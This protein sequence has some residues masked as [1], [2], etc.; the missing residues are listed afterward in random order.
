MF[1]SNKEILMLDGIYHEVGHLEQ[2]A[3]ED[4]HYYGYL[5][6]AAL[7]SSSIKMLLQSPKT[8][9]YVTKYGGNNNSKALLIGKL[10]HLSV[11]EPHKM[12]EVLV[13]DVQSRATKKFKEVAA[14]N[15]GV[16]VITAAEEKEVRRLQDHMLRN[17]KVLGYLKD[18][19]FEIPR[20]DM[21]DGMPFRAKADILQGDHIIDLKTTSDLHA[22]K[23]SAYKYGYDIQ[24]YIYCNLFGIPPENFHFVAIDKGSLDIGVY[25][26]SEDFYNSGKERTRKGIEL[27]KKFFQEGIDLD[28]YYIEETL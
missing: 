16:D 19:Q 11:L 20:V 28:G 7:S 8:Y 22:F 27:Y 6:Q 15:E 23:Y 2:L 10:F 26:V 13:V 1:Y 21:L 12:D 9:H 5:G 3:K 24:V 4:E 14:E 17:E 18:A 25:H